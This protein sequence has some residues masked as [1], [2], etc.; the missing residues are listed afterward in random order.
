MHRALS[1]VI[2]HERSEER[3][4][5][6][7]PPVH[8]KSSPVS[9]SLLLRFSPLLRFRCGHAWR[10]SGGHPPKPE[11]TPLSRQRASISRN[12]G[13]SL[14]R[15]PDVRA[16]PA[17]G[18]PPRPAR[19]GSGSCFS[20]DFSAS[21]QSRDGG[22]SGER[23]NQE[24]EEKINKIKYER[25]LR[26]MRVKWQGNG[27][28]N[29]L[30]EDNYNNRD[31]EKTKTKKRDEEEKETSGSEKISQI[32]TLTMQGGHEEGR[33]AG[34]AQGRRAGRGRRV[35]EGRER[36]TATSPD[37]YTREQPPPSPH[38]PRT[39]HSEGGGRGRGYAYV[40]MYQ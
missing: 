14:S 5:V 7:P 25:R 37:V 1:T 32:M 23:N 4:E 28:E 12:R 9:S 11:S 22:R 31:G 30:E 18:K 33:R 19:K 26:S 29:I 13:E 2:R 38:A 17:E 34:G 6:P 3:I 21:I 24:M 35:G 16:P 20:C 39:S 40:C 10:S 27:V 8:H 36:L 15:L